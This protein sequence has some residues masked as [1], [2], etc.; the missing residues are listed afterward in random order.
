MSVH[1]EEWEWHPRA[2]GGAR[3]YSSDH[4]EEWAT[5]WG[6]DNHSRAQLAAQAPAMAR[7]LLTLTGPSHM[8]DCPFCDHTI[9]MGADSHA[10]VCPIAVTLRAAGVLAG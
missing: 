10:P 8:E 6:D 3:L 7:L 2:G 4:E 1:N 5:T 9:I